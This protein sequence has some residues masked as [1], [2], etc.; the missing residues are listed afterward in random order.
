MSHCKIWPDGSINFGYSVV[1][2]AE[3]PFH[4]A[5]GA[6]GMIPKSVKRFSEKIMPKLEG[7]RV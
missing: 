6:W 3:C 2:I 1:C 4:P 5:A 7:R